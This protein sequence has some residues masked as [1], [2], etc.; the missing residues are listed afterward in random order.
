MTSNDGT[1]KRG[2]I[3]DLDGTLVDT[4]YLH[5]LAWS[6]SL[7]DAGEQASMSSIHPLI[8][9]SSDRLVQELLGRPHEQVSEGHGR[10][11]GELIDDMRGF[12][13]AGELLAE[14]HRRGAAVVIATSAKEQDL[15]AMMEAVGAPDAVVDQIV[16]AAEVKASKPEPDILERALDVGGL[17]ADRCVVVGDTVWD[18]EAATRCELPCVAVLT[19]GTGRAELETAGAAAVYRDTAELLERLDTSPLARVLAEPA[20]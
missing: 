11:F 15:D 7:R 2:V 13:S 16:H 8:G 14:V 4:T 1:S 17:D 9:M 19:G 12:P 20:R 5:V 6:R 18:V 10:H 3:F